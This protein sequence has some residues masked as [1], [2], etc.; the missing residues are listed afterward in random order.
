ML[1]LGGVIAAM[2]GAVACGSSGKTTVGNSS[3]AYGNGDTAAPTTTPAT[4]NV[5]ATGDFVADKNKT[6]D[7][8]IQTNMGTIKIRLDSVHAPVASGR[9]IELARAGFYNN[10]TFHRAATNFVIQGGDPKGDGSGGSGRPPV[11][12]ETPADSYPV[13]SLAAAKT[14]ADPPGTFDCQFFIVTGAGGASLPNDYARFG[15]VTSGMDV[16][17][18]IEGLAPATGDGPPTKK[19]TMTKVT[20]TES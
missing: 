20:I 2:V 3:D 6:Y 7:A 4:G 16:A 11:V 10:L 18:K 5:G 1:V 19:V 13:G 8:T 15:S 14:G 17:K 9:F 12:G